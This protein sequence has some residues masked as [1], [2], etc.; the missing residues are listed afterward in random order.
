VNTSFPNGTIGSVRSELCY[1]RTLSWAGCWA[2]GNCTITIPFTGTGITVF[3]AQGYAPLNTSITLDGGPPAPL[4]LSQPTDILYRVPF[5][6]IQALP[7]TRHLLEIRLYSWDGKSALSYFFLDYVGVAYNDDVPSPITTVATT[8]SSQAMMP[9][10]HKNTG[11]V[12]GVAVGGTVA[13]MIVV[14]ALVIFLR[15]RTRNPFDGPSYVDARNSNFTLLHGRSYRN[16][17]S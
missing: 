16:Q 8:S 9:I 4:T 10:S 14:A 2:S 5:Y 7:L 11:I 13:G 3:V 15:N 1:N 12:V 17:P 6:A